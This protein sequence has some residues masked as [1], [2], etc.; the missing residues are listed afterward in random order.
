MDKRGSLSTERSDAM[1]RSR[2]L[3][4]LVV[5][6]FAPVALI[7]TPSLPA[8]GKTVQYA[9][10]TVY[11]TYCHSHPPTMRI[12][13][14]DTVVTKTRDASN[15]AFAIT[16]K[17]LNPKIDLSRVNPQTG[18]F[19]VEGAEPGD[20]LKVH[21]D[22]ISLNRDWGW[23]GSIPYFG[24]LAPEYKTMLV[25]SPVKDQLFIWRLDASKNMGILDLP[26]SKIGKVTI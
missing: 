19:Y 12:A 5:L 21:I 13:S 15:D 17:T 11:F 9:P 1:F 22:R 3:K 23:G 24:A 4:I 26:K 7:L 20:T 8:S 6:L 25:T 14:G 2:T 16:D 18:P 10:Q